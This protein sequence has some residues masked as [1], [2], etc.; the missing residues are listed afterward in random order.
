[1]YSPFFKK[2]KPYFIH[3]ITIKFNQL[4][5]CIKRSADF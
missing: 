4:Q 1:M 3:W 2:Q 5:V